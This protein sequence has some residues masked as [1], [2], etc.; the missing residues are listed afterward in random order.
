VQTA[1]NQGRLSPETL[2]DKGYINAVN[3]QLRELEQGRH[4]GSQ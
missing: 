2:Q 4:D 1:I 3:F